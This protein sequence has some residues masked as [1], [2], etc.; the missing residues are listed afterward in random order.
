MDRSY[1]R[2]EI[3]DPNRRREAQKREIENAYFF[4]INTT[5]IERNPHTENAVNDGGGKIKLPV[6]KTRDIIYGRSRTWDSAIEIIICR[7]RHAVVV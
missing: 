3:G 7:D 5:T 1:F 2:S 6:I 4:Q